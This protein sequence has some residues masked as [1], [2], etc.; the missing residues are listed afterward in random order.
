[1]KNVSIEHQA[2]WETLYD[3]ARADRLLT[4]VINGADLDDDVWNALKDV[5]GSLKLIWANLENGGAKTVCQEVSES[6]Y[7][8]E[9]DC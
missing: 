1:M 9:H 8:Q 7:C 4:Q 3:T 2:V 6:L 5:R